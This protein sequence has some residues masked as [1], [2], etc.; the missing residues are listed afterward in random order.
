MGTVI[1]DVVPDRVK[2]S[3]VIFDIPQPWVSECQDVKNYI[4]PLN[5][6]WHRMLCGCTHPA[7]VGVKRLMSTMA[8]AVSHI[9]SLSKWNE[10]YTAERIRLTHSLIVTHVMNW[11]SIP[12]QFHDYCFSAKLFSLFNVHV[13][14]CQLFMCILISLF[15]ALLNALL[16]FNC[17]VFSMRFVL[18]WFAFSCVCLVFVYCSS[19]LLHLAS[20]QRQQT[21]KCAIL[22]TA[23]SVS[24]NCGTVWDIIVISL[25]ASVEFVRHHSTA[26]PLLGASSTA[27]FSIRAEL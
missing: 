2:T 7:T 22:C 12:E 21:D 24:D 3:L 25:R 4:W 15:V 9:N 8:V 13:H 27:I 17:L 6:V 16:P 26:Q 11:V 1:K 14:C 20:M 18:K 23:D 19:H 10:I 5:P